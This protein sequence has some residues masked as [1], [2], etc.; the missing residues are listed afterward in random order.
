M[1]QLLFQGWAN[2]SHFCADHTYVACPDA[3]DEFFDCWGEPSRTGP[4][5]DAHLLAGEGNYPVA[6][7][8]RCSLEY[9]GK[10]YPDTACIGI[11][12]LNGVCHRRQT[13]SCL[14]RE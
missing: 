11:Y 10:I 6:N 8:Y 5:P 7:C 12:A 14:P 2:R 9:E 1:A 13:A 3:G 4:D